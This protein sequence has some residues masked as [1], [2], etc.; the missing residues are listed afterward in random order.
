M[1]IHI[2]V[3]PTCLPVLRRATSITHG[4]VFFQETLM[5]LFGPKALLSDLDTKSDFKN[6]DKTVLAPVC[7]NAGNHG[8]TSQITFSPRDVV[9]ALYCLRRHWLESWF[10]LCMHCKSNMADRERHS[11]SALARKLLD[12]WALRL[13]LEQ[14][15]KRVRSLALGQALWTLG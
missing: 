13:R 6:L 8:R 4:C 5:T 9:S 15:D 1:I 14:R 10:S 2:D 11:L 7:A 3:H 12:S